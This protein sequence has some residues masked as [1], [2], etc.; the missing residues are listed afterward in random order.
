[1]S[2]SAPVSFSLAPFCE[3]THEYVKSILVSNR[4]SR[5]IDTCV[6]NMHI[7]HVYY[8]SDNVFHGPAIGEWWYK[9]DGFCNIWINIFYVR[10]FNTEVWELKALCSV[11]RDEK[12]AAQKFDYCKMAETGFWNIS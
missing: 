4:L 9:R 7:A 12:S 10:N 3:S 11:P 1:M 2:I 5:Q 6:N 8:T